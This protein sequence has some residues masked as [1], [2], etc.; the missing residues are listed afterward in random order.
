MK[1]QTQVI[2]YSRRFLK[3]KKKKDSVKLFWVNTK[4]KNMVKESPCS[5]LVY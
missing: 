1:W 3:P 4:M 5:V 2:P